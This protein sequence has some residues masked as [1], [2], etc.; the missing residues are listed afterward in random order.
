MKQFNWYSYGGHCSYVA[1]PIHGH[2][3][4]RAGKAFELG[5]SPTNCE[6]VGRATVLHPDPGLLEASLPFTWSW[7]WSSGRA[8]SFCHFLTCI[9]PQG[10]ML[11]CLHV[12]SPRDL[13]QINPKPKRS[14]RQRQQ[15]EIHNKIK[16]LGGREEKGKKTKAC[17]V[18]FIMPSM[19]VNSLHCYCCCS[20]SCCCSCCCL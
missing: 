14:N 10:D 7:P 6:Y 19:R 20:C 4:S 18:M 17:T 15:E 8:T 3:I 12:N 2:S 1:L 13:K 9:A 11:A 5:K 16:V